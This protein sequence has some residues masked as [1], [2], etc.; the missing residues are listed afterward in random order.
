MFFLLVMSLLFLLAVLNSY[1]IG[2]L[3]HPSQRRR[4]RFTYMI[5][6]LLGAVAYLG[7]RFSWQDGWSWLAALYYFG[8]F[9]TVL[10]M[11]L[12]FAWPLSR[13][14]GWLQQRMNRKGTLPVCAGTEPPAGDAMTRRNFLCRAAM[15]PPVAM[16][17]I[18]AVG[19]LDAEF[20]AVLRRIELAYPDLPAELAG[21]KIGHLTDVHLGPY[22]SAQDIRK[23]T[24]LFQG[25]NPDLL[26]ITGDFVDDV[27][28]L[29]AAMKE[30][31]PFLASLPLGA[32]FCMGNHEHL[33]G[34]APIRKILLE[35]GIRI[36]DNAHQVLTY[37]GRRFT[38][39]GV[40][41][42]MLS[43]AATRPAM[44]RLYLEQALG[45]AEPGGFS[46]LMAHHPDF[47]PAAF[48]RSVSL[49]LSGH[50]HGGQVGWGQGSALS[51]LYP[52]MRGVYRDGGSFGF[53]SSGAGHWLPFRLN[54][55]P[56][57]GLITLKQPG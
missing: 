8:P 22:V 37:G 36:L 43:S 21:L 46:V 25:E 5:L 10:Q 32:W 16:T 17:G 56:E 20:R 19:V 24:N 39:A 45:S 31:Q 35:S 9:W 3:F 6:T 54:C 4:F 53:V 57:A 7:S 2:R 52:Y 44:A 48:S 47:L 23:L 49:T 26:L 13:L 34:A 14:A 1:W 38:L 18:N 41:Y 51:F 12:V 28:L 40:D 30:I 33:R 29:P 55:P 11:L 15:V 42:P 27:S 50:T